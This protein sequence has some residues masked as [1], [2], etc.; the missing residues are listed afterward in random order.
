[1]V[2]SKITSD[3]SSKEQF[4]SEVGVSFSTPVGISGS[5]KYTEETG[6]DLWVADT[7]E[8]WADPF[9]LI[10]K[11]DSKSTTEISKSESYTFEAV[12][13]DTILVAT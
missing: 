11:T 1:M 13:G 8:N 12:G 2:D 6:I 4:K 3:Q 5:V 9:P 7:P 10:G